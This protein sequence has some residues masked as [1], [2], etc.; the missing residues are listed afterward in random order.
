[1]PTKHSRPRLFSGGGVRT[2]MFFGGFQGE[3]TRKPSLGG[4]LR[5]EMHN[6]KVQTEFLVAPKTG[7]PKNCQVQERRECVRIRSK[8]TYTHR[9]GAYIFHFLGVPKQVQ[10]FGL[11]LPVST[12]LLGEMCVEGILFLN[13][14]SWYLF[15]SCFKGKPR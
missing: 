12:G 2:P 13:K 10:A 14:K 11:P 4:W 6:Q 15:W 3:P 7:C 1:M 9:K 8:C 5:K